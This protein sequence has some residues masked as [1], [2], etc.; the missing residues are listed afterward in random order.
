[1][2]DYYNSAR[3]FSMPGGKK[4]E[5]Q[6]SAPSQEEAKVDVSCLDLRVGCIMTTLQLP[7]TNSLYVEVDVG[8]AYH[9]TVVS[10]LVKH[11]PLDQVQNYS[12]LIICDFR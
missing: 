10:E 12:Y 3:I 6:Q 2:R 5:K 11:I 1:M 4:A 9:R 7:E 8:E